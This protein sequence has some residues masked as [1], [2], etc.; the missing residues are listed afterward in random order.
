MQHFSRADLERLRNQGKIRD[1]TEHTKQKGFSSGHQG[2]RTPERRS[3]GLEWLSWNLPFFCNERALV[4]EEEF[5]FCQD[6]NWRFDFAIP[7]RKI[8]I[9]Y[10]G[11]IYQPISG[12]NTAKHYTKDTEKYNRA[13]VLGWRVIRVTALNYTTALTTL[14]EMIQ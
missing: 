6:R 3:K 8:A 14:K 7:D 10:E 4:L 2:A 5:K 11:G 12:H 9:E 13:T 1:F